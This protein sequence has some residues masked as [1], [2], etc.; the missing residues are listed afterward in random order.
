MGDR[1]KVMKK[2]QFSKKDVELKTFIKSGGR[3]GA[4]VDFNKILQ[5]AVKPTKDSRSSHKKK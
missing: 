1:I 3:S 4:E 2:R 5:R